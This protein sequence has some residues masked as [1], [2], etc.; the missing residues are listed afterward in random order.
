MEGG[1]LLGELVVAGGRRAQ[2]GAGQARASHEALGGRAEK[3]VDALERGVAGHRPCLDARLEGLDLRV[4]R[5]D[6]HVLLAAEVAV[7][8]AERD[9]GFGG[10]VA[11]A[12]GL[13]PAL[14]GEVDGGVDN[15]ACARVHAP[16]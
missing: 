5:R 16:N 13:E 14:L 1:H 9:V 6:Q 11:Q 4:Q 8:G 12:N 15:A 7:E 10:H 2:D 3:R